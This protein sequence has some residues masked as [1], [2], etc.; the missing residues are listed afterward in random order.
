MGERGRLRARRGAP[1][2]ACGSGMRP[3]RRT[4]GLRNRMPLSSRA[5]R[6]RPTGSHCPT[7]QGRQAW[8]PTGLT[9]VAVR[10]GQPLVRRSRPSPPTGHFLWESRAGRTPVPG[11]GPPM[12]PAGRCGRRGDRTGTGPRPVI[13]EVRVPRRLPA[14]RGRRRR[15]RLGRLPAPATWRG[16]RC[17]GL[18]NPGRPVSG[19]RLGSGVLPS[20]LGSGVLPRWWGSGVTPSLRGSAVLPRWW[21]SRVTPS[22]RG[23]GALPSRWQGGVLLVGGR[24]SVLL[25]SRGSPCSVSGPVLVPGSMREPSQVLALAGSLGPVP[26]LVPSPLLGPVTEVSPVSGLVRQQETALAPVRGPSP[27]L[28][29]VRRQSRTL[30][31]ATLPGRRC[32][33]P[34]MRLS[35]LVSRRR[36]LVVRPQA[37]KAEFRGEPPVCRRAGCRRGGG[38]EAAPGPTGERGVRHQEVP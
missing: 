13:N 11:H 8:R 2:R 22:L 26:S 16:R 18:R 7:W 23:S 33:P 28:A 1:G 25:L 12:R 24:R 4:R 3:V 31:L 17:G 5:F 19:R 15:P 38:F 30:A 29:P 32:G 14:P 21:G 34:A 36:A 20:W 37:R 35:G 10:G 6:W 9:P 27:A